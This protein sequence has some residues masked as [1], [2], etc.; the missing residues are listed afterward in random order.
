MSHSTCP[1]LYRYRAD[2]EQRVS[3]NRRARKEV[4]CLNRP[5]VSAKSA[6]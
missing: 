6:G 5:R 4:Q 3:H 1:R 2:V